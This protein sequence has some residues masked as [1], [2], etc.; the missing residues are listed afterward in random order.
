MFNFKTGIYLLND[1]KS[2]NH[3]LYLQL[4]KLRQDQ[5]LMKFVA[6]WVLVLLRSKTGKKDGGLSFSEL[7]RFKNLEDKNS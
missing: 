5:V 3:K 7:R 1:Q 6:R 4:N 2:Q